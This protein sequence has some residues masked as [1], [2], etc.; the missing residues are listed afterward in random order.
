MFIVIIPCGSALHRRA[1]S[2]MA[3]ELRRAAVKAA[4]RTARAAHDWVKGVLSAKW[5]LC[6]GGAQRGPGDRLSRKAFAERYQIP[7]GTLRDWEQQRKEPDAAAK[8]YLKVIASDPEAARRALDKRVV[9][10]H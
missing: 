8:A 5:G 3:E 1:F 10:R 6:R 7:I 2:T 4:S 9:Q